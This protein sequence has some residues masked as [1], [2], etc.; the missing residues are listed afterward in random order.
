MFCLNIAI[1]TKSCISTKVT[2]QE[3]ENQKTVALFVMKFW[4]S[5]K[6]S[7]HFEMMLMNKKG[8]N[9]RYMVL[10]T[11]PAELIIQSLSPYF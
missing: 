10:E 1:R 6:S 11:V 4:H 8:L 5:L 9:W 3:K 2:L 7:G